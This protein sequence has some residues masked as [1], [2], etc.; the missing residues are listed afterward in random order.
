MSAALATT[1]ISPD[2]LS[3]QD[4]VEVAEDQQHQIVHLRHEVAMVKPLPMLVNV[5]ISGA[6]AYAVSAADA[7]RGGSNEVKAATGAAALAAA[8]AIGRASPG[9]SKVLEQV[10]QGAV[11]ALFSDA[12]RDYGL[13]RAAEQE[14][15]RAAAQ[16]QTGAAAE[17]ARES[18]AAKRK[19]A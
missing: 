9:V 13:R 10:G 18:A 3:R 1:V 15:Q 14:R 7:A 16:A 6:T 5:G 17:P 19:A 2:S 4:L 11:D 8:L 12:G